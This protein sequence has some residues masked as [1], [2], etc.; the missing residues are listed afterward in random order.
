MGSKGKILSLDL[1]HRILYNPI[2]INKPAFLP[3]SINP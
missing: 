1:S 2:R 3:L